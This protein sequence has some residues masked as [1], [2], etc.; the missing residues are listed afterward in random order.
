MKKRDNQGR[1]LINITVICIIATTI[2]ISLRWHTHYKEM[3][4]KQV[5]FEYRNSEIDSLIA[6]LDT[7][8]PQRLYNTLPENNL[9]QQR[10]F[11]FNPNKADSIEL[12]ELGFKPYMVHNLLRYRAKGGVIYNTKKFKQ[13]YGIDT[14]LIS[15]LDK[16]GYISYPPPINYAQQNN[17]TTDSLRYIPKSY[18]N[19]ELNSA[20]TTLL[21][22]LPNIGSGRARQI[23]AYRTILGGY[24]STTQL[25]EIEFFHDS[26]VKK[27][28]PYI[29]IN[30]DSIR[31]ININKSSI[32]TLK[33]HPYINY[34]QAK[35]IYNTRWDKEHKGKITLEELKTLEEF[36]STE[37]EKVLPYLCE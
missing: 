11:V 36:T 28:E 23:V 14:L 31:L 12:L 15:T 4:N 35:A 6:H 8:K 19:F 30:L 1:Q 9:P 32:R 7:I 16:N 37:L 29:S 27:I 22:Q 13:I 33:Q 34:Y 17:D 3:Y 25:T 2:Y 24:H 26:I 21:Q 18:F 20:D 10:T 5:D